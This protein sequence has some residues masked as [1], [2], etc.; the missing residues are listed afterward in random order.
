MADEPLIGAEELRQLLSYD[1][2]TG[3]LRWKVSL[4][5]RAKVGALAGSYDESRGYIRLFIR[6]KRFAAHRVAW[7]MTHGY[8][9][10]CLI[11]HRD[12][13]G[14]NNRLTN[15]R[16]ATDGQ[17][18][19]NRAIQCNNRSGFTGVSWDERDGAWAACIRVG[20][21]LKRLGKYTSREHAAAAYEAAKR[22][23]HEF[24]PDVV[25]RPSSMAR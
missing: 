9:P 19:Q 14:R 23:L 3:E 25:H 6:G 18:Q 12:G 10:D 11:D 4:G 2:D 24:Q 5:R 22:R 20:G 7:V 1:P 17:N 21:K 15:L 8:W 13:D 16:E